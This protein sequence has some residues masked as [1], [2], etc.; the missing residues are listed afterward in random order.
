MS[1]P[2]SAASAEVDATIIRRIGEGARPCDVAA[3]LKL[4]RDTI[5]R[6][7][8]RLRRRGELPPGQPR[9]RVHMPAP[10]KIP[11]LRC[12]RDFAT[13]CRVRNRICDACKNSGVW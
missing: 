6:R 8:A 5:D 1:R 2:R 7:I 3:G 9:A 4:T 11:C 10:V 13:L 12:R